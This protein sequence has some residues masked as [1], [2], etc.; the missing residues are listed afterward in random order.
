MRATVAWA[1]N[2]FAPH[3][4]RARELRWRA[5]VSRLAP[6]RGP[7][8]AILNGQP[9]LRAH[10]GW[11]RRRLRDGDRLLF[12]RLPQGGGGG[13]GGSD[14]TRAILAI[15]LMAVAGPMAGML[16]GTTAAAAAAAGGAAQMLFAGTQAAITFA[17]AAAINALFPAAG[18][19][20]QKSPSPTY[21]ITAQGNTARLDQPI[22]VQYGRL[23]CYPDFAAMPYTEYAGQEQYLYQL[24][25][26]GAGEYDIEEVRIEDTPISAFAEVEMQVVPP[27]GQVTLFPT[28]VVTSVEVSGAEL[29]GMMESCAWSRTGS[30][31]TVTRSDHGL[32]TGACVD[33]GFTSGGAPSGRYAVA[34][35]PSAST[36]TVACDTGSSG[37]V[38][39]RPVLGGVLGYTANPAQTVATRLAVDFVLPQGLYDRDEGG[40]MH[41][42]QIDVMVEARQIDD[43]GVEIGDWIVLENWIY[44]AKT[45]QT[46][47][48]SRV[49][50]LATPGRYRVRVW[51]R[52]VD[53]TGS[54]AAEQ[55]LWAGLRA[56]LTETQDFGPV[57]LVA[58]RM[59]ATNNLSVASSRRVAM[60]A[61]RKLPVW[62]GSAWS[63]PQPTRSIAWALADAARDGAYGAGLG[64]DRLDLAALLALD[65]VW[66][67]RGDHF[68]GR[69]DQSVTWWEAMQSIAR[70]GRARC[71]M[72]GGVLRPVRDGAATV[73]VALFGMRNIIKDSFA[74]DYLMPT[75]ATADG[76]R[77]S[78]F[79]DTTWAP[80]RVTGALPGVTPV[81]PTDGELFGATGRAHVL[82]EAVYEAATNRYRRRLV[83]FA[84]E[85]EGFIPAYGD[86]I[87][88][89]HDM[90]GW[91]THAEVT[92]WDA[93]SRV[94][95][96]TE[97]VVVTPGMVVALR[98]PNGSVTDPIAITQGADANRV[99]LATAPDFTPAT[100]QD[101]E[102]TH[103][104]IGTVATWAAKAKVISVRPRDLH[105][106]EIEAVIDDPS[107]H[108][109]ETGVVAPPIRISQLQTR[110]VLPV[111]SGLFARRVLGSATRIVL[112]WRP[113]AGA[114]TY[115]VEMAAGDDPGAAD[116]EWMRV[117]DTSAAQAVAELL[118]AAK[119]LIRVR[120]S[121][122][123]AGPWI[124]TS[125][126]S[127][128]P[129]MWNPD[130]TTPM[131]TWDGDPM[132]SS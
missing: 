24:L 49:Y 127:L 26:L 25:C 81:N 131:W 27:G 88:V 37:N 69:F 82:R 6:R 14:P 41:S 11:Q 42:R 112:G 36:F 80:Q 113:A 51:R 97:P 104:A 38:N 78:Y 7:V 65:A 106:V 22:P 60:L 40:D 85:M 94:L 17:G 46:L 83:R 57:T 56:Y 71:V 128:I 21:S 107:V 32:T 122:M 76:I 116:L 50:T 5:P 102:R 129:E 23:L 1:D 45:I 39:V 126:G 95:A 52:D 93:A 89:Q 124:A 90:P 2:P 31:I 55:I 103:V 29:R 132:W 18:P 92:A 48:H 100:G 54:D 120:G 4:R 109:A 13:R 108:T 58:M 66:T 77:L 110:I 16:L 119:T 70:T 101:R 44:S 73:P 3:Q 34:S 8:I 68:D 84:T 114:D 63:A 98:R 115:H 91:G 62:T 121:G 20:R 15:A 53:H 111:V 87:A 117:V 125:L 43:L 123:A 75:D 67:A 61:T 64:D 86:L 105:S 9:L 33:L 59:R 79:D 30:V 19:E 10:R 130:P 96:L 35:V 74:L 118:Y 72:Q 99:V 47:R 28:Q 12:V